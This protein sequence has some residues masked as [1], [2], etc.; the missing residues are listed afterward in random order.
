MTKTVL[1]L[2][3]H[4]LGVDTSKKRLPKEFY[5]NRFIAGDD[6]S[7]YPT[8]HEAKGLGWMDCSEPKEVFMDARVWYV[9][10]EGIK[11]FRTE[12]KTL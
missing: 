11:R 6:H 10:E 7:D 9:T 8:L 2:I 3:A 1:E 12:Y 5:R 4:S